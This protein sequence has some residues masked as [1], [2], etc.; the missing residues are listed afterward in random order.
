MTNETPRVLTLANSRLY[1]FAL[2]LSIVPLWLTHYLPMVDLPGHAAL[3]TSLRQLAQGNPIFSAEFRANWFTPYVLGYGLLYAVSLLVPVAVAAK[4]VVSV[5]IVYTSFLV[6]VLL[7]EAAADERWKWLAI[8]CSYSLAFY[9]GFLSF[10]VAIPIALLL[11]IHTIRFDRDPSLRRAMIVAALAVLA[12]FSHVIAMGLGCLC[13]L[14]YIAGARYRDPLGLMRRALPYTAPIPLIVVWFTQT[15]SNVAGVAHAP[16]VYG[17]MRARLAYLISQP[18]GSDDLSYLAIVVT[19]AIVLLP[20]LCGSRFTSRPARWL[21]LVAVVV[22]YFAMPSYAFLSGFLYERLGLFFVP[23]WLL[24]FDRPTGPRPR[25]E[26]LAMAV[27]LAWV[28]SNTW[29]FAAF[30][31][32]TRPFGAVLQHMEEGRRVAGLMISNTS[33]HFATPVYLHFANWYQVERRGVVDFNFAD[34]QMIVQRRAIDRPRVDE[35]LAVRPV[36][37][38]WQHNG[39]SSY[40]YFLVRAPADFSATLFKEHAADVELVGTAGMWWLYRNH[41]A[42]AATAQSAVQ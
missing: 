1:A 5:S 36:L 12:F 40:D 7:R 38:D 29:R 18:S 39:G 35:G 19:T 25:L 32:E 24:V 42:V 16:L 27:V 26:W 8:P 34:F 6:G 9:W 20:L 3:M 14:A 2:L 22:T 28:G 13:A 10:I 11:L 31:A 33:T 30:G 4:V 23:T 37:F 17:P 15:A 41:A 21:P